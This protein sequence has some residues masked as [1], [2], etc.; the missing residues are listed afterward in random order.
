MTVRPGRIG[1]GRDMPY[2]FTI[3]QIFRKIP[4]THEK[5]GAIIP[6]FVVFGMAVGKRE[7][8]GLVVIIP[9]RIVEGPERGS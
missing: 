3:A 5:D 6:P 1:V 9:Q 7:R 4:I 2:I 8:A